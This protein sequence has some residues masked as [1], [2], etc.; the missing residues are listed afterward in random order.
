[1]LLDIRYVQQEYQ[2]CIQAE[3][4]GDADARDVA[5]PFDKSSVFFV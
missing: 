1:M 2:G 3:Y 5:K 4:A